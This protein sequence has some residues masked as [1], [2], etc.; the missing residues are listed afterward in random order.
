MTVYGY[1]STEGVLEFDLKSWTAAAARSCSARS[2]LHPGR[3]PG[4]RPGADHVQGSVAAVRRCL[5]SNPAG[6]G[7][8]STRRRKQVAR[9]TSRS[10]PRTDCGS[11]RL[12]TDTHI[13]NALSCSTGILTVALVTGA[14]IA[15]D[16]TARMDFDLPEVDNDA[17]RRLGPELNGAIRAAL[18]VPGQ[19]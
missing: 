16:G 6:T 8:S 13:L 1:L 19:L 14:Q 2:L 9:F 4:L 10:T 7:T 11:Q 17:L 12:H 18:P 3:W 15:A 5:R